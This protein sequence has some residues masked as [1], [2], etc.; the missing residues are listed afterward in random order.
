MKLTIFEELVITM[1]LVLAGSMVI[2]TY[3]ARSRQTKPTPCNCGTIC[4]KGF[5]CGLKDCPH[6]RN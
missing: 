4:E 1:L 2:V 6:G 3:D 5:H